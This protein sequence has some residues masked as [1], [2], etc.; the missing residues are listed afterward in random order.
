MMSALIGGIVAQSDALKKQ[1]VALVY[2]REPGPASLAWG[3][4]RGEG[5]SDRYMMALSDAGRAIFVG[6]ADLAALLTETKAAPRFSVSLA[7]LEKTSTFGD[8]ET[9]PLPDQ[10]ME[11]IEKT[12]PL[13]VA[14]T[15]GD[16]KRALTIS[17]NE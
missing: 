5:A 13:S 7:D 6:S 4:Y 8:F 12:A 15:W 2:C 14:S 11:M 3:I 16:K 1:P 10:A 17:T 9:L